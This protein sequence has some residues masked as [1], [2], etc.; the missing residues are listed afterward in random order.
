MG[1]LYIVAT[2]IGNRDD[3]TI[4]A[5]KIL[6]T[7][8]DVILCEDT[9]K[10]GQLLSHYRT[11]YGELVGVQKKP[12]LISYYDQIE[13]QKVPE[14]IE[15]LEHDQRVALVSDAGTPL[16]A[17]PGYK[18]V[19]ECRARTIMVV[20]IPGP[21]ALIAA[22]SAS[23]L[24]TDSFTF[25]GYIPK[26][27]G[28]RSLFLKKAIEQIESH[29]SSTIILYE[30]PHRIQE[31]LAELHRDYAD[32]ISVVYAREMTKQYEEFVALDATSDHPIPAARGE[33]VLMLSRMLV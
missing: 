7:E 23:G 28:K 3:I 31:T 10:T 20:P 13:E 17:D 24:P 30:T 19:H 15:L 26:K 18:L 29:Y 32:R 25:L 6:L 9:R 16:I 14:V 33:Y 12:R 5:L 11:R 1:V 2:P 8:V 27:Q 22:L 21:S 4:R